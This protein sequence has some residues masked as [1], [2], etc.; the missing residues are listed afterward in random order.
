MMYLWL[1]LS[2]MIF[3]V[4]EYLSKKW[5]LNSS[6]G[7]AAIVVLPYMAGTWL[8]LPALKAGK[9]LSTVGIAWSIMSAAVTVGLG[10]ICFEEKLSELNYAGLALALVSLILLQIK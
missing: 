4:G 7:L 3:G 5:A 8:W 10:L 2:V 6:F 9:N 1:T